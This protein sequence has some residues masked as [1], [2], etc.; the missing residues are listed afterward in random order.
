MIRLTA[1]FAKN[2]IIGDQI[3]REL[4]MTRPIPLREL[5][6]TRPIPREGDLSPYS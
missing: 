6:M 1:S 3:L 4:R 5:R 2:L